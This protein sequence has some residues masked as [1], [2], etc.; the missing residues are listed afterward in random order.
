[1]LRGGWRIE[2]QTS[3]SGTLVQRIGI[4]LALRTVS[5]TLEMLVASRNRSSDYS[6]YIANGV[7]SQVTGWGV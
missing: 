2:A 5:L 7:F 4:F 1:M 3:A 6:M